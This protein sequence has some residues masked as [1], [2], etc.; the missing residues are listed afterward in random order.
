MTQL[1]INTKRQVQD[2]LETLSSEKLQL[3]YKKAVPFVHI[4]NELA[5]QWDNYKSLRGR[6][7][8]REIWT[9]IELIALK[10]FENDFNQ[11]SKNLGKKWADVPSI[12][13]NKSW[14]ELMKSSQKCLNS[15]SG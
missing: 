8:Y 2:T 5:A 9:D 7:W 13:D 4:P 1:Q 11:W 12:F 15:I 6:S 3:S 10:E 14:Q